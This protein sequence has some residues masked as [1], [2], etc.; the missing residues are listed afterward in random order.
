MMPDQSLVMLQTS[1][2]LI[3]TSLYSTV[4]PNALLAWQ[5]V[6]TANFQ[7]TGGQQ[8]CNTMGRYNSGT[9]ENQYMVVDNKLFTPGAELVKDTLWVCEQI[10]TLVVSADLTDVLRFGYWAS[11]NI[12][13]FPEVY[14]MAG[15]V[16]A[17]KN[18]VAVSWQL[19]PR[20]RLFRRDAN[21]VQNMDQLKAL[22]RYNDYKQDPYERGD[23]TWAICSRGDFKAVNPDP[24]G[25]FDTKVTQYAWVA[26]S[27]SEAINGPTQS[28]NLPAFE[29]S[30]F[31]DIYHAG[32]PP[33]YNFSFVQMQPSSSL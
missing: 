4:G 20:A 29:W 12:P 10:P 31:P 7:A 15:Y 28:H 9:Y 27:I 11:Y 21:S 24:G 3:N 1:L 14:K 18:N 23:P 25:C 22:M 30:Q 19:A 5:R 6:R 33:V 8:W 13:Y 32:L 2:G 26:S 17:A 16:E